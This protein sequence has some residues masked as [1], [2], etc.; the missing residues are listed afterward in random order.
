MK[1]VSHNTGIMLLPV[2]CLVFPGLASAG[3]VLQLEVHEFSPSLLTVGELFFLRIGIDLE[4]KNSGDDACAAGFGIA[5]WLD[6]PCPSVDEPSSCLVPKVETADWVWEDWPGIGPGESVR[7][8]AIWEQV[9]PPPLVC[10][11]HDYALFVASKAGICREDGHDLGVALGMFS[12]LGCNV[13]DD[14]RSEIVPPV[15]SRDGISSELTEDTLDIDSLGE[16]I[17]EIRVADGCDCRF[18]SETSHNLRFLHVALVVWLFL[19]LGIR[20]AK[21]RSGNE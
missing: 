12:L 11:H 17:A 14:I 19:Y 5:F 20:Q 15:R 6:N 1:L 10:I 13:P 9:V 21:H 7:K 18:S 8:E 3:S 16:S 2:F 4:V